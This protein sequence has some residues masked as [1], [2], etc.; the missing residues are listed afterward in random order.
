MPPL[1]TVHNFTPLEL[2]KDI[3]TRADLLE[4]TN[5]LSLQAAQKLELENALAGLGNRIEALQESLDGTASKVHHLESS[6]PKVDV[7]QIDSLQKELT[8]LLQAV[9]QLENSQTVPI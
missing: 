2:P 7:K 4:L 8:A 3:L 1:D 6:I 9:E 5:Q